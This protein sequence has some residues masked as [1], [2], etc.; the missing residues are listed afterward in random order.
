MTREEQRSHTSQTAPV[1]QALDT[2]RDALIEYDIARNL[3]AVPH[4]DKHRAALLAEHK[5]AM[6]K[7]AL[8]A[9]DATQTGDV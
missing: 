7:C 5:F 1:D 6:V 8:A 3:I 4:T 9:L 2:L